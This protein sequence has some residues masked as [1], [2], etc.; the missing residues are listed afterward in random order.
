MEHGLYGRNLSM[1]YSK[2]GLYSPMVTASGQPLYNIGENPATLLYTS[3]I[4]MIMQLHQNRGKTLR[5]TKIKLRY[6]IPGIVFDIS[7]SIIG[8]SKLIVV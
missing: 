5:W 6:D 4:A 8:E 1:G 3:I 7:S 2:I